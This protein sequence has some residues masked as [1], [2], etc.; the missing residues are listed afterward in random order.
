MCIKNRKKSCLLTNTSDRITK[1]YKNT[2][3]GENWAVIM[4]FSELKAKARAESEEGSVS[5]ESVEKFL[6][7]IKKKE[8]AFTKEVK[9]QAS[10][11]VFMARTYTL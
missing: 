11:D 7:R 9:S 8:E 5:R 10:D 4:T 2:L 6:S 3:F 1:L